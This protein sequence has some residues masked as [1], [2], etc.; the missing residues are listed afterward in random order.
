MNARCSINVIDT[1]M[2]HIRRNLMSKRKRKSKLRMISLQA[3]R[4]WMRKRLR[5]MKTTRNQFYIATS[6]MSSSK[7]IIKNNKTRTSQSYN[8]NHLN[9]Q[10]RAYSDES[11][12]DEDVIAAAMNFNWNKR[13][14]LKSADIAITHHNEFEE[15]IMIVE[16]LINHCERTTNARDKV[17]KIYSDNQVSLKAI[18]VMSSMFDQKRLQRV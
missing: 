17:Y 16:E 8:A 13:K 10:W 14:R 7:M 11:E 18:H 6:W 1:T 2:K 5:K 9:L 15:L 12:K 3:K 4:R